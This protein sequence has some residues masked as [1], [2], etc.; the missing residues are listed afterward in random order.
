ME[1]I[2]DIE[3]CCYP[4]HR[5]PQLLV[6]TSLCFVE[7]EASVKSC[8]FFHCLGLM[9]IS[10]PAADS[11]GHSLNVVAL[12]VLFTHCVLCM[13]VCLF[14]CSVMSDSLRPQLLSV[15]NCLYQH[16]F[17]PPHSYTYTH[18]H[19]CIY[20]HRHT[21]VYMHI[22]LPA[23]YLCISFSL[24]QLRTGSFFMDLGPSCMLAKSRRT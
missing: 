2:S 4:H 11:W 5:C 22:H 12:Q 18:T 15:P 20:T 6:T 23:F 10:Q 24:N 16:K 1:W 9:S 21:H 19:V 3:K 13:C 17:L 7:D 8:H 14:V